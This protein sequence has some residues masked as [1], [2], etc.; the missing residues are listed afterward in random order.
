MVT[1]GD[2]GERSVCGG[3]DRVEDE[4]H[5]RCIQG[6][7]SDQG[8]PVSDTAVRLELQGVKRR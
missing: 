8:V 3:G 7:S 6:L 1:F 5:V 2:L 4:C